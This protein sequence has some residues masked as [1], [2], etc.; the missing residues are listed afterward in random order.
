MISRKSIQAGISSMIANVLKE[1]LHAGLSPLHD[2]SEQFSDRS[3]LKRTSLKS[4]FMSCSMRG[5]TIENQC[6]QEFEES[7]L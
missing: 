6:L 3:Y 5:M 4:S 7:S 1:H 2:A